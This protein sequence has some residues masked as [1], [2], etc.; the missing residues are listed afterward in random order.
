MRVPLLVAAAIG[1]DTMPPPPEPPPAPRDSAPRCLFARPLPRCRSF[2]VFDV[3]YHQSLAGNE[4][5][6][7]QL[8]GLRG[9]DSHLSWE[10]GYMAN[11]DRQSAVGGAVLVGF[12]DAG[13]RIGAKA[14]YRRW[15]PG[16]A[17]VDFSA[18]LVSAGV[19]VDD[20]LRYTARGWGPSG[21]V[22]VGWRDIAAV[23]VRAEALRTPAGTA[24]GVYGGVRLGGAAGVTASAIG[25]IAFGVL[26]A[27]IIRSTS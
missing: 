13:A 24:T 17:A 22:S 14:R 16:D 19:R 25:G 8:S 2:A 7:P 26:V 1:A 21:D 20:P 15:Q 3:S 11:R 12:D 23:S 9:L 27:L 5:R 10:V 18:G 6:R 4:V